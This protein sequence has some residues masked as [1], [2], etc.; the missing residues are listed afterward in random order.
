MPGKAKAARFPGPPRRNK[1][2]EWLHLAFFGCPRAQNV[3]SAAVRHVPVWRIRGA[4]CSSFRWLRRPGINRG[5]TVVAHS[6]CI[7]SESASTRLP[8]DE[9]GPCPLR[10]GPGLPVFSIAVVGLRLRKPATGWARRGFL[11]I[12]W[13][14]GWATTLTHEAGTEDLRHR[15]STRPSRI[16]RWRSAP[17]DMRF[18]ACRKRCRLTPLSR[19]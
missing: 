8:D 15:L 13:R 12:R 9:Y 6:T 11:W 10:A 18:N 1:T 4:S 7:R 16:A 5:G 17:R 3:W 19:G 14:S 2:H